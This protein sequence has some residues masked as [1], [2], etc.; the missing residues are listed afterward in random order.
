MTRGVERVS[1]L[2]LEPLIENFVCNSP[3]CHMLRA[4]VPIS[5]I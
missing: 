5:L 1:I 2:S 3:I 4:F